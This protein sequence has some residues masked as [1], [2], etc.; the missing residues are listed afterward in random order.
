MG[1]NIDKDKEVDPFGSEKA[2]SSKLRKRATV[3]DDVDQGEKFQRDSELQRQLTLI[4]AATS[5]HSKD[6][7]ASSIK[8][9][10][11]KIANSEEI[12]GKTVNS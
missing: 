11:F 3:S 5:G 9:A 4:A 12:A 2:S 10:E 6:R 7:A 1:I 8:T